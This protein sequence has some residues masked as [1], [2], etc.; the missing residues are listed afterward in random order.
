MPGWVG[1][2]TYY[3][4]D[5]IYYHVEFMKCTRDVYNITL[6]YMGIWNERPWGNPTW[7]KEFRAA[8]DA[9]GFSKTQIVIPDGRM[10]TFE[11]TPR[12]L[13]IPLGLVHVFQVKAPIYSIRVSTLLISLKNSL[14]P[15]TILSVRA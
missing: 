10:K 1:N 13:K 8:M 12:V 15:L 11:E 2:G 6:D 4:N 5:S 14:I 9:A 7:V 3:S